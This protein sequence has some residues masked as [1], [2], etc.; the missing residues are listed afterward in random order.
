MPQPWPSVTPWRA[1]AR[2]NDSGTAAPPTM[3]RRPSGIF[4]RPGVCACAR[5]NAWISPI[6][7]VGTPTDRVGGSICIRS[8]RSSGCRCGP[9]NTI[10]VPSIT[11]PYGRPQQLAWNIGVTGSITSLPRKSQQSAM[12]PT[13]VCSTVERCEYTTP[14]GRPV[15]PDV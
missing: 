12:Q 14:L 3:E 11:A 7:I 15:V 10:L 13:S 1:N 4:Q 2:I 6:Q 8:S 5:S 9:G